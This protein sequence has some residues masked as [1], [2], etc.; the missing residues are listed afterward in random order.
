[1]IRIFLFVAFL[2]SGCASPPVT[3]L[4]HN[5][6][7][8][9]AIY[10]AWEG[11]VVAER[12]ATAYA[13]LRRCVEPV[14]RPCSQ[15]AVIDQITKARNVARDALN[16]SESAVRNPAFGDDVSSTAVVSAIAALQAFT[17]ISNSLGAQ[18]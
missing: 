8:Q 12:V 13:Q 2:L 17:T 14:V 4:V 18:Q 16:A 5:A 15:Q 3:G 9:R 1:M 6:G 7:S 10:F 11:Y